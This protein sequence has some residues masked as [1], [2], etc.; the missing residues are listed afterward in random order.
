MNGSGHLVQGNFI[1]TDASGVFPLANQNS[2]VNIA[3]AA[4]ITIGGTNGG[5]GNLIAFNNYNGVSIGDGT[6][7][8]NNGVRGNSIFSNASLGI[9]RELRP[10]VPTALS[11]SMARSKANR[12]RPTASSS[13]PTRHAIRAGLARARLLSDRLPR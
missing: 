7:V 3:N 10:S 4:N 9:D 5:A 8:T 12:T 1:G 13:S 11:Q 2:G 6:I